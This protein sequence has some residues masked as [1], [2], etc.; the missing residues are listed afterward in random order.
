MEFLKRISDLIT[1]PPHGI[2]SPYRSVVH[3]V[4]PGPSDTAIAN[5]GQEVKALVAAPSL[6]HP[7]AVQA[8]AEL[9][10]IALRTGLYVAASKMR[11]QLEAMPRTDTQ[12][13]IY[14][15][16][17]AY[18]L[19]ADFIYQYLAN[20]VRA[21][22]VEE[23]P[24][25]PNIFRG[26]CNELVACLLYGKNVRRAIELPVLS[27]DEMLYLAMDS[28]KF[29]DEYFELALV[30][31]QSVVSQIL[32]KMESDQRERSRRR[33][34]AK[35]GDIPSP[36]PVDPAA[37]LDADSIGYAK[38]LSEA[39]ERIRREMAAVPVVHAPGPEPE[40]A[41]ITYY[42]QYL[43]DSMRAADRAGYTAFSAA[44]RIRLGALIEGAHGQQA[45]AL[46]RQAATQFESLGDMER[47]RLFGKLCT[48]RYQLA[49][50]LY[51]RV[52]DHARHEAVRA[53]L[54]DFKSA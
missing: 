25:G 39:L 4:V 11:F 47:S 42:A 3:E 49:S 46:Y 54:A 51:L 7:R 21:I 2:D 50:E 14:W 40:P 53:K 13:V 17:R 1:P 48:R 35:R 52:G 8:V 34:E 28:A 41:A 12:G 43:Q 16:E 23:R 45:A 32:W 36:P 30:T 31:A 6:D 20:E 27:I 22:L 24:I 29:R 10:R 26:Y 19:A 44:L 18:V 5:L 9:K 37:T 15:K 33:Q 38:G